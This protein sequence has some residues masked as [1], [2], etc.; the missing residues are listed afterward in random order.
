M[1]CQRLC[2]LYAVAIGIMMAAFIS[3]GFGLGCPFPMPHL[4][5]QV[6]GR[7]IFDM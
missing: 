7:A 3:T 1:A 6:D 5:L 2:G 4:K